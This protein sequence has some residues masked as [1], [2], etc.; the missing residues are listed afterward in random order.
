MTWF[1]FKNQ[2]IAVQFL[3]QSL[4]FIKVLKSGV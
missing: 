4:P 3:V 1:T 2:T